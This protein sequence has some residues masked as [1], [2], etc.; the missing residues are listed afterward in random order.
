MMTPWN[1]ERIVEVKTYR[2]RLYRV[3]L[4]PAGDHTVERVIFGTT[5]NVVARSE[6]AEAIEAAL[7][8]GT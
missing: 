3:T 7:E 8:R 2:G 5:D 1:G 6:R 4:R